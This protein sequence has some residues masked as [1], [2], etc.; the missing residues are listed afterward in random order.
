[1]MTDK[2]DPP[3]KKAFLLRIEPK[4]W[5]ELERW[6]ADDMRSINGQIEFLLRQLVL[7]RKKGSVE[8]VGQDS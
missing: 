4:L 7:K 5:E 2:T 8:D 3:G 6:A 1:M